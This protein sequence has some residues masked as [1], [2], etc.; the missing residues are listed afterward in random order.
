MRVNLTKECFEAIT[1]AFRWKIADGQANSQDV[2]AV[3]EISR[4]LVSQKL[5]PGRKPALSDG[6]PSDASHPHVGLVLDEHELI[7]T[8]NVLQQRDDGTHSTLWE[9]PGYQRAI[10][11]LWGAYEAEMAASGRKPP[12]RE[13][14][15]PAVHH[16]TV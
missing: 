11:L 12:I 4:R 3:R 8:V 10:K 15:D 13:Q 14:T 5:N 6:K 7:L 16:G 9:N 1:E 2:S